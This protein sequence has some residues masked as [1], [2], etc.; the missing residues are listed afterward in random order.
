MKGGLGRDP[1]LAGL[2]HTGRAGC[3]DHTSTSLELC[4]LHTLR[5]RLTPPP[6]SGQ[7]SP[8]AANRNVFSTGSGGQ[9][10]KSRSC[11]G[12]ASFGDSGGGSVLPPPAPS[13]SKHSLARGHV[14]PVS[15]HLQEATPFVSSL[16]LS[17]H[18]SLQLGSTQSSR[19]TSPQDT[20]TK[21]LFP[22]QVTCPAP[23]TNRCM[24]VP[25][26]PA[27]AL[28]DAALPP[29]RGPGRIST[30][31]MR[32]RRPGARRWTTVSEGSCQS[33]W[34]L[35]EQ[36]SHPRRWGQGRG[37][38]SP[39]VTGQQEARSGSARGLDTSQ[40]LRAL[41]CQGEQG[42]PPEGCRGGSG[43]GPHRLSIYHRPC[44]AAHTAACPEQKGPIMTS[45]AGNYVISLGRTC[46]G[47][48][49]AHCHANA[50]FWRPG[51]P[52]QPSSF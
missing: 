24:A 26:P 1:N 18:W 31:Q 44:P 25:T 29:P 4:P 6:L 2:Q 20:A 32:T 17:G 23:G 38:D 22:K 41:L 16:C 49:R 8:L 36:D 37:H 50:R 42:P 19:V 33:H 5:G 30:E 48:Q 15:A 47:R 3:G 7:S 34:A 40:G 52:R 45:Q 14:P 46:T 35:P 51:Q 28:P 12:L 39:R 13:R 9:N 21:T 10:L 11:Q 43:P 27:T